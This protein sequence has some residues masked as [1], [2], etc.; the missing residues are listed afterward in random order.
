VAVEQDRIGSQTD[1]LEVLSPLPDVTQ[2]QLAELLSRDDSV[3]QNALRR[4][5]SESDTH[6][7][8]AGFNSAI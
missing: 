4:I 6:D 2:L 1:T 8:V 7:I 3:L 5:L